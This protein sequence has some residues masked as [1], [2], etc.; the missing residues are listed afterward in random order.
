M[1]REDAV[2]TEEVKDLKETKA[3]APSYLISTWVYVGV[4]Q[5][6]STRFSHPHS[7]CLFS[8]SICLPLPVSFFVFCFPFFFSPTKGNSPVTHITCTP[9]CT[10]EGSEFLVCWYVMSL[11]LQEGENIILWKAWSVTAAQCCLVE[12]FSRYWLYFHSDLW[13]G[14]SLFLRVI[15]S[16][17][18][19]H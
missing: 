7:C 9:I 2:S 16:F 3:S 18:W 12:T 8:A 6:R 4:C 15:L 14:G 11:A 5:C 13:H 19:L 1:W 10:H 17:D